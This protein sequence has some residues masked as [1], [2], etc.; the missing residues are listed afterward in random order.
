MSIPTDRQTAASEMNEEEIKQIVGVVSDFL[1]LNVYSFSL[2]LSLRFW[3]DWTLRWGA[4]EE[5]GD[6]ERKI[7]TLER[8]RTLER[9]CRRG[10]KKKEK[11]RDA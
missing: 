5:A 1:C 10:R 7:G 6:L 3:P 2:S 9:V 11:K 8:K 4:G